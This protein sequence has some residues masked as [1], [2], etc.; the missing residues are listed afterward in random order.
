MNPRLK[1]I[2]ITTLN[3]INKGLYGGE[4]RSKSVR[5]KCLLCYCEMFHSRE[6]IARE[7]I[8]KKSC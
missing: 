5:H 7:I 1:L 8:D 2:K 6:S 3:R 4:L